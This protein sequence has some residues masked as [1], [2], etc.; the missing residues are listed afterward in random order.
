MSNI[1]NSSKN[2]MYVPKGTF[3]TTYTC[4]LCENLAL[5]YAVSATKEDNVGFFQQFFLCG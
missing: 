1:D 5:F 4:F 2:A 3:G